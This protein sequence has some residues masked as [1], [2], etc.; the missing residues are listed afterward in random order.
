[1]TMWNTQVASLLAPRPPVEA[2]AVLK[3]QRIAAARRKSA[4]HAER[5]AAMR[6]KRIL[7]LLRREQPT[8]L[9]VADWVGCCEQT[10]RD[11]MLA[12]QREGACLGR[13]EGRLIVWVAA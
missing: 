2:E 5:V 6:R 11:T 8:T 12:L 1:M 7:Q 13:R 4:D 10:A 3:S 9:R